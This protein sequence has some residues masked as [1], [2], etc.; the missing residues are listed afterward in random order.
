MCVGLVYGP[1]DMKKE[2]KRFWSNLLEV[3]NRVGNLVLVKRELPKYVH[4]VKIIL[5]DKWEEESTI[6][7]L[8]YGRRLRRV[9]RR[10]RVN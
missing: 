6:I 5:I 10:E 8:Y 3:L 4:D 7:L 1:I 9:E 2:R